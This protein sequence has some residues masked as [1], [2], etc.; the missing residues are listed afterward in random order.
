MRCFMKGKIISLALILTLSLS[1]AACSKK[2]N[3]A[4]ANSNTQTAG[5]RNGMQFAQADLM[6]E[7]SKI[8]GN[9]VTIKVVKMPQRSGNWNN[10]GNQN[11]PNGGDNQNNQGNP[12]ANNQGQNPGGTG[13]QHDGQPNPGQQ[14][15]QNGRGG[16]GGPNGGGRMQREYTGEE[17]NI[18]IPEGFKIITMTRGDNGL[19][20]TEV[21]ISTIKSGSILQIY[22]KEDGKTLDKIV[23]SNQMGRANNGGNNASTNGGTNGGTSTT[24]N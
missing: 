4:D 10:S 22:F 21:D 11:N 20:Q 1:L 6:G 13:N 16:Q 15:G 17:K 9:N 8:E 18:T 23:L 2:N 14:G 3:E 12:P 7:V 24:S 5:N 19:A